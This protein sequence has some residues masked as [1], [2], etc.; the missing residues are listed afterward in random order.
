M[1]CVN[2]PLNGS[3]MPISPEMLQRPGPEARVEQVQDR[4]LDAADILRDR[5]PFFGLGPIERLVVGWLAKRMK[6]QLE[7]T[8]VSS[9]S[10]SRVAAPP[11]L[12]QFDMLPGRMA[13][14]RIAGDVE[15]DVVGQD[16]RQLLARHGDRPACGAMDDRDRR[17]PVALARH[18]PV[19]QA[20]LDRALAPAARS[21]RRMTSAVA[22]SV[23]SPSR[24][25]E[26]TA[27]P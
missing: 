3:A 21:A 2:R 8:K 22:C 16:D 6:Y 11:Q 9:V 17:A 23:V 7:S 14:E 20:I 15:A 26:L 27:I 18:A 12:G 1:P 19:A 4:M 24:N 25:C 5:Q 10:V 13:V